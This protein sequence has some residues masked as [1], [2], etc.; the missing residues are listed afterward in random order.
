MQKD[1][2]EFYLRDYQPSA[3]LIP[4]IDIRLE[5]DPQVTIVEASLSIIPNPTHTG[6]LPPLNLD[7]HLLDLEYVKCNG[8]MLQPSEYNAHA[9]GITLGVFKKSCTL[10]FRLRIYPSQNQELEGLY[11]SGGVLC[12]QC[13]AQ[14]FRRICYFLDRP[15][16]LSRWRVHLQA[17]KTSY[18]TLLAGGDLQKS[19]DLPDH[20]H[21]KIW[22]DPWP[23]P[24]YLFALTAGSL[25]SINSFYVTSEGRKI[26][27]NIYCEVHNKDRLGFAMESIKRAM[28]WD[29]EHYG[30]EYDLSVFNIVAVDAFNMGAMENKGLN[31]FNAQCLLAEPSVTC[32]DDYKR[33]EAIIA[34]EYFH[35]WTG[36]RVTCRDWF[37]LTLK[38]GLTVLRDQ[39]FTS[40]Y[41][42]A[43]VT[44][45][46]QVLALFSRQ[47]PEDA[48]AMAHPIQPQSYRD[49]NN[50]YTFTVYEKGAEVIRM[51]Y[52]IIGKEKFR[53]GT[54]L[55]FER[56]DG[57]AVTTED[58]IRALEDANNTNLSSI[59]HWYTHFRTP[60]V[61]LRRDY[62]AIAK[63]CKLTW[64][65]SPSECATGYACALPIPLKIAAYD[66]KGRKIQ[67]EQL[68]ILDQWQKEIWL[69]NVSEMPVISSNRS[70]SAPI[71]LED[72][73]SEQERMSL[74]AHDDDLIVRWSSCLAIQKQMYK[75]YLQTKTVDSQV[76]QEL[77]EHFIQDE[78]L[79]LQAKAMLLKFPNPAQ[80]CEWYEPLDIAASCEFYYKLMSE[81]SVKMQPYLW[82]LYHDNHHPLQISNESIW[83]SKRQIK[84]AA[85]DYLIFCPNSG[86]FSQLWQQLKQ[87]KCM[88]DEWASLRMLCQMSNEYKQSAIELF[89][90][91]WHGDLL[92]WP[93][94]FNAQAMSTD[95]NTLATCKELFE[96]PRF[97]RTIPN[98]VRSL[99]AT[100]SSNLQIFHQID[101]SGYLWVA[102]CIECVDQFNAQMAAKLTKAFSITPRL[103]SKRKA[104]AQ[105]VLHSLKEKCLSVSVQEI[106]DRSLM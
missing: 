96:D 106:I 40:S 100:L 30:R 12:T 25:A 37:Q 93:R 103:D 46:E 15:D 99:V 61:Q 26:E 66:S 23:K 7:G 39:Q 78:L 47:F 82:Q 27:V 87:A 29:E 88:S 89:A 67:G 34:H 33:I 72:D 14:G 95:P 54:D 79:D 10:T 57:Q 21:E 20:R 43:S 75:A 24:C 105:E 38:E 22:Y 84:H 19:S 50:F 62:D 31:I 28:A 17:D 9:K 52:T 69:E 49:I 85:M 102:S 11:S 56:H 70:M 5:L 97:D 81:C 42:S 83:A 101:G 55:Y 91:R 13:E 16:I 60:K 2:C 77:M 44:R 35:N 58:F 32:D 76:W 36:N 53:K 18:P 68:F 90:E 73:L 71:I 74:A 51:M 3:Y 48:G 6:P 92:A 41:H 4:Y 65:Q 63:R 64:S 94:W 8:R 80:I 104:R 98:Q 45:L 59:R 1:A 86:A